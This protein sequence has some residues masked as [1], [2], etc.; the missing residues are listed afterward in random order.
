MN[1]K[2]DKGFYGFII[3]DRVKKRFVSGYDFHKKSGFDFT[4]RNRNKLPNVF[5]EYEKDRLLRE[6]LSPNYRI[7][8]VEVRVIK[9]DKKNSVL[10]NQKEIKS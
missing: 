4:E 10:S 1:N 7:M 6:G 8:K 2:G 9:D 5:S 3:Y